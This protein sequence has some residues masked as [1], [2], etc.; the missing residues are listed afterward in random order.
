MYGR[1]GIVQTSHWA[2]VDKQYDKL[3]AFPIP[4]LASKAELI[5]I[6]SHGTG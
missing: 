4:P 2:V 1:L 6:D 5:S 3:L